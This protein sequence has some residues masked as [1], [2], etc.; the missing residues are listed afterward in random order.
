MQQVSSPP[1]TVTKLDP[2][3]EGESTQ[4]MKEVEEEEEAEAQPE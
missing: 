1:F 4:T 3:W 2:G